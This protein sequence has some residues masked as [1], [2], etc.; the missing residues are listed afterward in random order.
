MR[1]LYPRTIVSGAVVVGLCAMVVVARAEDAVLQQTA[2][3][4]PAD[5]N[6]GLSEVV[7]TAQKRSENLKDVPISISVLGSD[8]LSTAHVSDY[9]D[10]SRLVPGLSYGAGASE[11]LDNIEIRGVSSTSGSATVGVFVDDVSVTVKNFFDG[12]TQPKLFDLDRVEVLRG[13]QGTLFGA[14]SEGGTIRFISKQPDLTSYG[15]EIGTDL[16]GTK[17]GGINYADEFVVNIPIIQNE[18]AV[19]ISGNYLNNSGYIDNYSLTGQLL[20]QGTNSERAFSLHASV[21]YA[22]DEDLSVLASLFGQRDRTGDT[23][24]FYTSLPIW[25]QDKEVQESGRDDVLLPSLTIKD[26]LGFAE[27]TSVSGYFKQ[28]F[29]RIEDGTYY[30]DTV[31][32]TAFLDPL[33]SAFQNFNGHNLIP[34]LSQ[35]AFDAQNNSQIG[36]LPSPVISRSRYTEFSQ[37]LRLSSPTPA[38]NSLPLKWVAGLYYAD[39]I[40]SNQN[41][42]TSPGIN[43]VFKDLYGVPLEQSPV[44]TFFGAPGLALFPDDNNGSAFQTYEEHQYSAFGQVDF[45]ILPRLHASVGLRYNFAQVDLAFSSFGFYDIG[46]P[47]PFGFRS[48]FYDLLPKYVLSYDVTDATNVYAT[49]S[50]GDRLG[51]VTRPVPFG[52]GTVC[53][54]DFANIGVTSPPQT[55]ATDKLWNYELGTK[56][57]F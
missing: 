6:Q 56:I 10:L 7:V 19:R 23:S 49:I 28:F 57:A 25:T 45:D 42:E 12:S 32:A 2:P 47:S 33:Y 26:N 9:E 11:G 53:A 4:A 18:L 29:D 14:S 13:P 35:Q 34:G 39:Q 27:L 20:N 3:S 15:G 36:T 51:G 38:E 44:E 8:E 1:L 30:N 55:F 16:S 22:P 43:Q 54:Q 5:Q 31:F 21:K 40:I 48:N 46:E 37:E 41:I 17:H 24:A 52:P 50:K